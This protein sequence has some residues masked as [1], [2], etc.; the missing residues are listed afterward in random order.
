MKTVRVNPDNRFASEVVIRS[1]DETDALTPQLSRA[2]ME[3]ATGYG[4][5][6][7]TVSDESKCYRITSGSVKRAMVDSYFPPA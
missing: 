1:S 3:I 6:P 2:A 7:G 4:W 5:T